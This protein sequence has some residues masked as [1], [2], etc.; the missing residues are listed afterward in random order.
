MAESSSPNAQQPN[1]NASF[2]SSPSGLPPDD[3]EA[4]GP[5]LLRAQAPF[6]IVGIGASAG[7]LDAVTQLLQTLPLDPGFAFILIQHLDPTRES[8]LA[9]V[10]SRVTG[11]PVQQIEDNTPVARNQV[12]VAPSHADVVIINQVLQ[13]IPRSQTRGLH[14]PIDRFFRSLAEDQGPHAIG[15]VLSGSGS[16]GALGLQAIKDHGGLTLVQDQRTA[17]FAGMPHSAMM[18]G[19]IDVI[20]D[21]HHLAQELVQI[22]RHPYVTHTP[23]ANQ[24][25]SP[26]LLSDQEAWSWILR[27]LHRTT[28]INFTAYKR[29][30]IQRRIARRMALH[31]LQQLSTYAQYLDSHRDE[32]A[33]LYHDLFIKVT[34]FFRDPESFETLKRDVLPGLIVERPVTQPLRIWVPGCATGEE[35]YSLAICV[36]EF[37]AEGSFQHAIRLFATDIDE[38]ALAKARTGLY[39]ENIALDVSPERLRR[40]FVKVDQ[41][42]QITSAVRELCVFAKHNLYQDPPFSNL[43]LII[44]RNVLIYLETATQRRVIPLFHY[45]L[46]PSGALALGPSETIG[47]FTD[48]FS[49]T[50]QQ[51]KI[52][53]KKVTA[54]P[55]T[56]DFFPHVRGSDDRVEGTAAMSEA[57]AQWPTVDLYR[58]ADRLLLRHYVPAAVLVSEA[59]DILQFHG[60]TD[61]YLRPPSGRATLNLFRMARNGLRSDLLAALELARQTGAQVC[62]EGVRFG[63]ETTQQEVTIR[64]L[65][66]ALPRSGISH[67]LVVFEEAAAPAR[68]I[69]QESLL[70]ASGSA[71]LAEAD[72]INRLQ[73]ELEATHLY[74]QSLMEQ[75]EAANEEL[76]AANEEI[77]SSNEELQSTNEEL[78]T[79]KEELQSM[80]EELLTTN[81]EL[82]HRNHELSQANNDLSNLFSSVSLP[83]IMVG[84]DLRIRR[85]TAMAETVLQLIPT[86]IGRPIGHLQLTGAIPEL[87]SWILQVIDTVSPQAREVQ[88]RHGH[89]Y[90]L[91]IRP[92]RTPEHQIDGAVLLFI[93]IDSLKDVDRLTRLLEEVQAARDY[94]ERI[95]HTVPEPLVILGR[96]LRVQLANQAF[97]QTFHVPPEETEQ[98]VLYQLGNGQWDIPRLRE[99][100]EQIIPQYGEVRDFEVAHEF[101]TIGLRTMRL[102]ARRLIQDEP[103]GALI[104]LA[105]ED[106]TELKRTHDH[107]QGAVEE[108]EL[109]LRELHHRV[110]NNLQLVTSLLG[111]QA[112]SLHDPAVQQAFEESQRRI[113]SMALVHEQVSQ[114]SGFS[115]IDMRAYIRRLALGLL[116]AYAPEGRIGLNIEAEDVTVDI[117]TAIPCALI[118]TELLANALQH[119]FTAGQQG[120]VSITWRADG[121]DHLLLRVQDTGIGMPP[122]VDFANMDSLGV[123]LVQSLVSQIGGHIQ[124]DRAGGTTITIRFPAVQAREGI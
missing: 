22:A 103:S 29:S 76:K 17:G 32:V 9:E 37:L 119:A 87:E 100:L 53:T 43:D 42:Y 13:L 101:D 117:D 2:L 34:T 72:R 51:H 25:V 23:V 26:L 11:M 57:P 116:Q 56:G 71:P 14:M 96:E 68:P 50:N 83:I 1:E 19:S 30:T 46:Q 93:D 12:Y 65:P 109:L 58:E 36:L 92:Y 98:R 52:Y 85:F 4:P 79:A 74:L 90:S 41:S 6:L 66:L 38:L 39:I 88:D 81:D 91:R 112:D 8:G 15:I 84:H 16:D 102:N 78:E 20:G 80:N 69:S 35:A 107:L 21:P 55:A 31:N 94:A 33:A 75:Y 124:V 27:L 114:S 113:Q 110:K 60:D 95:L 89:W 18:H 59:M 105:I 47:A 122:E 63:T 3:L 104:L 86:D 61:R 24:E 7:G 28:G 77:V 106:I 123:T 97:Y 49:L 82:S 118:L 67:Y 54:L 111:L 121:E 108:K 40:F 48:L 44:C 99:L 45:A 62:R 70:P 5:S 10:L 64:V 120:E 73:Q 115:H